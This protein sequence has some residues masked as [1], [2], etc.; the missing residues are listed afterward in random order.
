MSFSQ[1]LVARWRLFLI[2]AFLTGLGYRHFINVSKLRKNHR[3][4][5][6]T[7]YKTHWTVKSGKFADY[8]FTVNG[9]E[10]EGGEKALVD[11]RL[12]GGRY[13]VKFHPPEPDINVVFYRAPVPDSVASAP[14]QGWDTPP[15]DVPA[16]VLK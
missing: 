9:V 3:Y 14:E 12:A 13:V 1:V 15:F 4:A 8:R 16:Q 10:Y 11:M 5:I 7:V 6:G 2:L